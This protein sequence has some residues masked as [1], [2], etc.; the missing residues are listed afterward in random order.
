MEI[1]LEQNYYLVE[2]YL[3]VG[4][5]GKPLDEAWADN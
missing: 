1:K 4:Q 3:S 5:L 2:L